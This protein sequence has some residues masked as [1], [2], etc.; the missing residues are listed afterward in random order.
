MYIYNKT[1]QKI[2]KKDVARVTTKMQ[3]FKRVFKGIKSYNTLQTYFYTCFLSLGQAV[4]K[5]MSWRIMS[6]LYKHKITVHLVFKR[7]NIISKN[8]IDQTLPLVSK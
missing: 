4:N 2:H 8:I 7:N 3:P 1:G 6:K 5:V